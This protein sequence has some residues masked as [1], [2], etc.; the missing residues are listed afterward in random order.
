MAQD[1]RYPT[2]RSFE[3]STSVPSPSI[4]ID[5]SSSSD[6]DGELPM[7]TAETLEP[8]A[9][10]TEA[11]PPRLTEPPTVTCEPLSNKTDEA[12]LACRSDATETVAS[13]KSAE[14][15]P[16]LAKTS[17]PPTSRVD[18]TTFAWFVCVAST[19]A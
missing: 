4:T 16:S 2:Y 1:P 14:A 10:E 6:A 8:P 9:I 12:L 15:V 5:T 18:E 11:V 7:F 13:S 17:L 3:T 19:L